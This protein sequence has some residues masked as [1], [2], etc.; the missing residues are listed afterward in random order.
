MTLQVLWTRALAVLHRLVDLLV[1]DHPAGVP[2]RAG[3]RVGGVRPGQPADAA[4]GALAGGPAPRRRRSRSA[5]PTCSPTSIPL[6]LRLAVCSRRSFG[7]DAIL[8]CQFV[9]RL[10][11]RAAGDVPDGGRLPA[12]DTDRGRPTSTRWGATWAA[13]TRSTRWAPSSGRS[14]RGSS[15]CPKLGLQRGIYAAVVPRSGAGRRCC[16]RWRRVS[17]GGAGR[18]RRPRRSRW[19][20]SGLVSAAL[21]PGQLLGRVLPR[22]DRARLHQ[23]ARS[24]S[25]SGQTPKLV[26]YED[27]IATTVSVDQW[28]KTFSMKNNGKVDASN[29]ADMP[30][31]IIVGLLPLLL[32]PR[33]AARPRWRWSAS[34]RASPPARSPSSRSRRWRWSSWSRPSTAPRTSSTTTTTARWRT[35]RSR[36]GSA[37]G[38]ISSPSAAIPFDVIVSEPSNPWITGVSNLFTREYFRRHQAPARAGRHLLPVGAAVRDG[39]LE[40]QDHLPHP[41]RGVPL[42]L[43]VRGRGSLVGHDPHRQHEA[44]AAGSSTVIERGLP[45]SGDARR[46]QAG[47]LSRRRTTCSPTCCSAPT[48]WSRSPPARPINTDDN[49]RIEFAAPRDLLGYAKFDPYLAKVYGAD[50]ALRPARPGSCAGTTARTASAARGARCARSLLAHGKAREAELWTRRAEA[51]AAPRRRSTR[52][53]CCDLVATRD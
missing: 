26:F 39:A 5:R 25:A 34:A 50:V 28:D 37:T 19:R 18:G 46:G 40:H 9:A 8:I 21:E 10:H 43:R 52:A 2:D 33:R 22:V 32:Y 23:R 53:C 17:P 27:G 30:T 24:R 29:D 7:V 15:C 31:Q 45:R 11:H 38:A 6:R 13:P 44:A 36:R 12:H 16:S 4:P 41:A 3:R 42:R 48:S 20:S 49:A 47:R 51:A 35:P 14:C 1:H